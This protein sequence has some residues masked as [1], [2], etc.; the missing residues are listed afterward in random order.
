[1]RLARLWLFFLSGCMAA[2]APPIPHPRV[3]RTAPPAPTPPLLDCA[4]TARCRAL[5]ECTRYDGPQPECIVASDADCAHSEA[6]TAHGKCVARG[7]AVAKTCG[8]PC[9]QDPECA[10]SGLCTDAFGGCVASRAQ[11]CER[12]AAC[13]D[14]GACGL[15]DSQCQ[16]TARRHCERSKLCRTAGTCLF[17][18]RF[19]CLAPRDLRCDCSPPGHPSPEALR[20]HQACVA[21]GGGW[22]RCA[23]RRHLDVHR[24]VAPSHTC[25]SGAGESASL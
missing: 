5:G 22:G 16:P 1:M 17:R 25:R 14:N 13:Q 4:A 10:Q 20:A 9:R 6:C 24:A 8:T 21:K 3:K 7:F 11:D 19:G 18:D 15:L 12:S 2:T 23:G